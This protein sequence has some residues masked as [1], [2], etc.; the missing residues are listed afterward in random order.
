[1]TTRDPES[2]F[3]AP[4]GPIPASI[5]SSSA[6]PAIAAS[7][8]TLK[9]CDESGGSLA[10]RAIYLVPIATQAGQIGGDGGYRIAPPFSVSSTSTMGSLSIDSTGA[11][12]DSRRFSVGVTNSDPALAMRKLR[13]TPS[14]PVSVV[15]AFTALGGYWDSVSGTVIWPSPVHP[16]V[17]DQVNVELDSLSIPTTSI[18]FEATQFLGGG[19]IPALPPGGAWLVIL[20]FVGAAYLRLRRR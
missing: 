1:V 5:P 6:R 20:L 10:G 4:S 16:N 11:P 19:A 2:P 15:T 12:P 13:I 9:L 14:P 18:Q 17:Q 7:D 8:F 3:P